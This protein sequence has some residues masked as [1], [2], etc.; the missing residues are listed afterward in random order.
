MATV[1]A[2]LRQRTSLPGEAATV[3]SDINR[4]LVRDVEDSGQFM[5]L[6]YMTIDP[7]QRY[8]KWI[9]AG[10]DPA[11][12]YDPDT[13]SF[14]ELSGSGVALGVMENWE[15]RPIKKRLYERGRSF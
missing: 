7:K 14:Q 12:F 5:T 8:L 3:I 15:F 6:F 4:Q 2:S 10:H 11:I 9:R 13:D 1:R